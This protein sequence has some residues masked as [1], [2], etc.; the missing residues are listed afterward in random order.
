[1]RAKSSGSGHT[2]P[3]LRVRYNALAA[4]QLDPVTGR[5][6]AGALFPTGAAVVKELFAART[7]G[8]TQYA[9]MRKD[10]AN[11]LA[12][13]TGWTWAILNANGSVSVSATQ[14]G[15]GCAGCHGQAGNVDATLMSKFF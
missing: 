12:T 11:A 3:W 4:G 10:P 1:M 9:V 7:G 5:P 15:A 6:R 13:P 8:P 14:K 2:T